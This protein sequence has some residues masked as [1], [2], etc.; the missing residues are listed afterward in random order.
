MTYKFIPYTPNDLPLHRMVICLVTTAG[1]HMK[2][3]PPFH[4]DRASPDISYRTILAETNSQDLTISNAA[5]LT[6]F[7]ITEPQ[8]DINSVFPLDRLKEL[9]KRKIIGGVSDHHYSFMGYIWRFNSLINQTL[10]EFVK[11]IV[12]SKTD[13]VVLSAG[14]PY[15]H[16]TVVVI[17]RAIELAGIPTVLVTV[18][19]YKSGIFRPS[20]AIHPIRTITWAFIR[21]TL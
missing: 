15:C 21:K 4:D 11:K 8:K 10:P 17:Q 3:Q 12:R 5:P 19:P 9:T 14:S 20:R 16:R 2:D 13:A 1:V 7:D 6:Q 18:D